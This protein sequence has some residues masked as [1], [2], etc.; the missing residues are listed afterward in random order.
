M[1][2]KTEAEKLTGTNLYNNAV[3]VK[4]AE[5]ERADNNSMFRSICP[6]CKIGTLLVQRDQTTLKLLPQDRCL[7]CGQMVVYTDIDELKEKAGEL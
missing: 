7:L 4:H 5:L 1:A 6:V 3:L 2:E